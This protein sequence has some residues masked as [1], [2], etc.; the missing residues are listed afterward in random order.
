MVELAGLEPTTSCTPS[1]RASQTAPQL[2][3]RT[4]KEGLDLRKILVGPETSF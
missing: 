1:K 4:E 2:D 3:P